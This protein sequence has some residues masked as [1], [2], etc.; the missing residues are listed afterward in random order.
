MTLY[1]AEAQNNM[2]KI[3][4]SI[5]P[6]RRVSDLCAMSPVKV[7]LIA[8]MPGEI[9]EELALHKRFAASRAW[10]EWFYMTPAV[11]AF[12]RAVQ[13]QGIDFIED[14]NDVGTRKDLGLTKTRRPAAMRKAWKARKEAGV[15][16]RIC[17]PRKPRSKRGKAS[18]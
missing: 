10:S 11:K 3:G 6:K 2:I 5:L 12:V 18:K 13:G 9:A 16:W 15:P 1:V 7:R 8:I 17:A 4:S 14:W